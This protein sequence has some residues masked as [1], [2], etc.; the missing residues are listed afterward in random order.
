MK[1][2]TPWISF[3]IAVSVIP[4]T[5]CVNSN[6][7][8]FAKVD[9]LSRESKKA[10]FYDAFE[11]R[12]WFYGTASTEGGPKSIDTIRTICVR[13]DFTRIG[14]VGFCSNSDQKLY[15]A[16]YLERN[17]G[18]AWLIGFHG[19]T[20]SFFDD[21]AP[22][23]NPSGRIE[24]RGYEWA[25]HRDEVFAAI[26]NHPIKK[27]KYQGSK[28]LLADTVPGRPG[29]IFSPYTNRMMKVTAS[30]P[31]QVEIDYSVKPPR[32]VVVRLNFEPSDESSGS[33]ESMNKYLK[34]HNF[35]FDNDALKYYSDHGITTDPYKYLLAPPT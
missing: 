30:A 20:S 11:D 31:G 32:Q 14:Q 26:R 8:S 19:R 25:F 16:V 3:W 12:L 18:Y 17:S 7:N 13:S 15:A 28:L 4:M 34:Q 24:I 22:Q 23:L 35:H 2:V 29:Y 27:P 21:R 10:M 1:K 5:S 6:Q 9:G 33:K